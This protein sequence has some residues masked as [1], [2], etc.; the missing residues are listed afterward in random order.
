[1]TNYKYLLK[2]SRLKLDTKFREVLFDT[3][4]KIEGNETNVGDKLGY[5]K[6]K[7]RRY[8]ELREG[9][10]KTISIHQLEK[11]SE[12]TSIELEKILKHAYP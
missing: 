5:V 3:A 4:L 2:Y 11:L 10:I 12:I 9:I 8:R 6:V 7:S 1:M